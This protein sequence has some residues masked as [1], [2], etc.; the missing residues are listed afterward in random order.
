MRK[1]LFLIIAAVLVFTV[2]N[3]A[4]SDSSDSKRE[5]RAKV[6][7]RIDNN[8]YWK[9]MA[10]EGLA[11]L[12]PDVEVPKAIYTGSNINS[13]TVRFEN[14]PDVPVTSEPSTQSENSIF[15]DPN[16]NLVAVNSNNSTPANGGTVYGSDYLY[17][18]DFADTWSGSIQAPNGN[19]GGDPAVCIGTDGRWYIGYISSGSGQDISYSD[20]NGNT[21]TK[22]QVA[23]KPGTGWN[24]LADKNHLWIDAKAGSP[25]E[26]Y[27]YDAWTDF[28]GNANNHVVVK[29]STDNGETWDAKIIL[30]QGVSAGSHSQGVNLSTGPNGEVYAVWTIYDGW[31]QDEKAIGFARSLDGGE[32]WEP[33]YRIIDNIKGIRNSEVPQNMRVNSFPCMAVDVSN[34]PNSGNIYVVW[35]NIGVPGVNTGSDRD[36]YMIK[37]VDGGLTFGDPIRVNQDPIGQGKAHYL[38]WITCDASTGIIST[39]FYDNRNTAPNQ[40]EAWVAVSNNGGETWE[41]F[42]VSDVAFT[43]SPI[44]GLAS[45]YFGD[46]LAIH[47][48]DGKVYPCWTDNRT[49]SAMTYVSVFE[50]INVVAPFGLT[51]VTDQ[52]TGECSLEWEFNGTTGFEHFVIY[53]DDEF[54]STTTENTYVDQLTEYGYYTYKVTAMY[55]GDT[56]S[57]GPTTETQ[58]GS[59]TIEIIPESYTAIIY[60]DQTDTQIMK[61]RNTGVLDLD[62]SISPFF[63]I[64]PEHSYEIAKGGGD[65]YIHSVIIGD[66]S[67]TSACDYYSDYSSQI[68]TIGDHEITPIEVITKNHYKED[69]CKVWID[70]NNNGRFDEQPINLTDDDNDGVFRGTIDF[71]TQNTQGLTGMR[72]RLSGSGSLNAYGDTQYGEVEDYMLALPGWL[73][74]DPDEGIVPP[75]DSL[76]VTVTFDAAGMSQGSYSDI[77][78]FITNDLENPSYNVSFTLHVTDIDLTVSADPD[79]I[80]TGESSQLE[81]NVSGGSGT[82]TY[83]WTSIPEGFSSDIPNPVVDP[84]QNTEYIVSVYDG[85]ITIEESVLVSV[86]LPPDVDLGGYQTLCNIDQYELDAGNPG[87]TYQ[88]STGDTTQKIMATGSGPTFFWVKVTNQYGCQTYDSLTLNFAQIPVVELGADT[89]ICGGA[90]ITLDAGNPGSEYLWSTNQTT[91]TIVADTTGHGIGVTEYSVEVTNQAGCVGNGSVSIEFIDCTGINELSSVDMTI[92]PN[93]S[94]GFFNIELTGEANKPL[95]I[96][97]T[98]V[99]GKVVYKQDNIIVSGRTLQDINISE[100]SAGIYNITVTDGIRSISQKIVLRK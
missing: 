57:D 27:L 62:F 89:I 48:S 11:V 4:I 80:C 35:T 79:A 51:A 75:G 44:P 96:N 40:A 87:A 24:D 47:A 53:R 21:W 42:K 12:N 52:E 19:N 15:I 59:S 1:F 69:Q 10:K 92:Y 60:P 88:W 46:Y 9:R 6:D 98:N 45:G 55:S 97:V 14:S 38:P 22:V 23:P 77:V 30:S 85:T 37:S 76:L 71:S 18:F 34:G 73:T 29:R 5:R 63:G 78:G 70:Y 32:T 17:T 100:H 41:D 93:P 56:E 84:Y 91:R 50:T 72:V 43:P 82:Y 31:P 13:R 33:S 86:Y 61:I 95:A 25:Y 58:F 28:G 2:A 66:F 74:L 90:D 67:N 94:D 64:I 81:A 99:S 8:G 7:T 68:I 65:E 3:W 26:N 20:D 39:I 16:N 36:I 54:I 49:G 83:S